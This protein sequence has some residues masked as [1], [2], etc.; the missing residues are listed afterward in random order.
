MILAGKKQKRG[1]ISH[2]GHRGKTEDT[3]VGWSG[4]GDGRDP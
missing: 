1:E 4:L 2:G 3:E